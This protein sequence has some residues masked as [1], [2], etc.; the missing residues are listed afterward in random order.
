MATGCYITVS[1]RSQC[2]KLRTHTLNLSDCFIALSPG[3]CDLGLNI[4]V[5]KE[6]VKKEIRKGKEFVDVNY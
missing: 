1:T 2:R 5:Y 3:F 4:D 6:S